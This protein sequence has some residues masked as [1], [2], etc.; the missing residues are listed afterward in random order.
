MYCVLNLGWTPSQ[1]IKLSAK[2]KAFVDAC[3][4]IKME[5]QKKQDAKIKSQQTS[6]R[7]K[8]RRR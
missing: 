8:I 4:I 3:V 1:Y 2:E 5:E 7:G 6:A